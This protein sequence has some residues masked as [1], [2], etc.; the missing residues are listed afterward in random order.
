MIEVAVLMPV[1]NAGQYV[2]ETINSVLEQTFKNFEF[3]IYNDG[4]T[5]DSEKEILKFK[6]K[7]I[8]YT[9]INKN[10]GYVNALNRGLREITSPYICR[11]DADDICEPERLEKQI[12]V[13]KRDDRI[14]VCGTAAQLIGFEIENGTIW[15]QPESHEE[16]VLKALSE[17]PII[18]PSVMFRTELVSKI[19]FYNPD[20]MPSED[21]DYW[22]RCSRTCKLYNLPEP[23]I[24]YRIHESQVS[25]T[26]NSLQK[27]N[28]E[29]I[30]LNFIIESLT[31]SESTAAI[32]FS[33]L[34]ENKKLKGMMRLNIS[35]LVMMSGISFRLK[36]KL[37]YCL[38]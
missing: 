38:L 10:A 19:G 31:C 16:I 17:N 20:V 1:Y 21:L 14:G 12:K 28:A 7:R 26:D 34:R 22:I 23:L 5:D 33:H 25:N 6:D 9:K 2:K 3:F 29:K 18:H 11:I 35:K 15:Y 30:H 4:S 32:I 37:L 24:R 27:N 36:R 8:R 13:L